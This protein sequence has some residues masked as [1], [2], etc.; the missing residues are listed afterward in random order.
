MDRQLGEGLAVIRVD[1]E[2]EQPEEG[3]HGADAK[4]EEAW[5]DEQVQARHL[6]LELE[7]CADEPVQA[8]PVAFE[9]EAW[10]DDRLQARHV[11]L[12]A[13]TGERFQACHSAFYSSRA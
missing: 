4:G 1:R 8:R 2:Q 12:E 13:W 10:A 5:A 9:L 6:V 7:A 3:A 11:Q